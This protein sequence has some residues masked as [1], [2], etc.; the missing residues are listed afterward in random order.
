MYDV[1]CISHAT[2]ITYIHDLAG[3]AKKG[4]H[5]VYDFSLENSEDILSL[6]F[7]GSTSFRVLVLCLYQSPSSSLCTYFDAVH[8]TDKI[9]SNNLS[10]NAFALRELVNFFCGTD[11]LSEGRHSACQF[12]F[13]DY[14]STAFFYV[15]L[16][17]PWICSGLAFPPLRNFKRV[18]TSVSIDFPWN[19][20]GFLFD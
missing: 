4:R 1:T 12:S 16:H 14:H 19:S 13:P 7:T 11:R 17:R 6:F 5:F 18:F 9:L 15:S 2:Y 20:K 3:Y 8:L 10:A